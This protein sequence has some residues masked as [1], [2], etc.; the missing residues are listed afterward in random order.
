MDQQFQHDEYFND[1]NHLLYPH[2]QYK[3]KELK[4][5]ENL[6]LRTEHLRWVIQYC[7]YRFPD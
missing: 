3:S 4:T 6:I 2:L 1:V 5:F 7:R